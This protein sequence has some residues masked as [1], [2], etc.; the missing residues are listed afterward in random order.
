MDKIY[1]IGHGPG[2]Y[3]MVYDFLINE[4]RKTIEMLNPI[5]FIHRYSMD[6]EFIEK[7]TLP[8]PPLSYKY[9]E[10]LDENHYATWSSRYVWYRRIK[11]FRDY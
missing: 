6:G 2:E 1:R 10:Q 5:G 7:D 3:V 4:D 8:N 11:Y 9:I